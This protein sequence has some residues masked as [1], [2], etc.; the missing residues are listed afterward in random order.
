MSDWKYELVEKNKVKA[1]T[2]LKIKLSDFGIETI[3]EKVYIYL[4]WTNEWKE[5]SSTNGFYILPDFIRSV[6]LKIK[7]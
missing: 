4:P 2:N 5:L 1:V 6:V 3:P 7:K